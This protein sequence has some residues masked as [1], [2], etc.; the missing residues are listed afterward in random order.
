MLDIRVSHFVSYTDQRYKLML[1]S[2]KLYSQENKINSGRKLLA[3]GSILATTP[4]YEYS[5]GLSFLPYFRCR[6]HRRRRICP[7]RRYALC[8]YSLTTYA[9]EPSVSGSDVLLPEKPTHPFHNQ[10]PPR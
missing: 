3:R 9:L 6:S 2:P 5:I 10:L 4:R 7:A 8:L 1:P